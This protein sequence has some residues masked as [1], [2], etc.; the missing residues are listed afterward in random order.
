MPPEP[1]PMFP[2]STVLFPNALLPLHVFETRFRA[3][4]K[5]CLAGDRTFGVVLISRGSEVGGG[6]MRVDVG[7]AT[8]I[9]RST[10]LP[11]G[12]SV[13][14]VRGTRRFRVAEWL[15]DDPFPR[16]TVEWIESAQSSSGT[17]ALSKA[18]AAVTR[19][20]ALLSELG[21]DPSPALEAPPEADVEARS[22]WLCERAPLV[23]FDRQ[24]LL[25]CGD[26]TRR[27]DLLS[28]LAGA[29]ADDLARLLASG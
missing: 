3:M 21:H 29:V 22:W 17:G 28:E 12:R 16:G 15:A 5:E 14:L 20:R 6:E 25:E 10:S 23:P 8:H 13:L 7:T 18:E 1:L 19:A 24:R 2:L 26:L 27:L 11:D 4:V 9:E